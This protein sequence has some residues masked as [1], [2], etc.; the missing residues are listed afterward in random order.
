MVQNSQF[1]YDV[2]EGG[3]L[4]ERIVVS[5]AASTKTIM[6]I[7]TRE[8]RD[9]V[10]RPDGQLLEDTLDWYAQ[11]D[12][13]NVWYL[14]EQVTN[15]LYDDQGHFLNTTSGGSWEAGVNGAV[16]G[17]IMEA[18]PT[19][20]D[21]YYQEFNAND[22][23]DQAAVLAK[24]ESATVPK[25]TFNNLLRTRDTSVKEPTGVKDKRYAPGIGIIDEIGYD[26]ITGQVIELTKLT[27]VTLNGVEVNQL[28]SPTASQGT[29]VA[30][31]FVGGIRLNGAAIVDAGGDMAI[32]GAT[33]KTTSELVGT[34]EISLAE[35]QLN[36]S[37]RISADDTIGLRNVVATKRVVVKGAENV[38]I[39]NSRF[40]HELR[41]MMGAGDSTLDLKGSVISELN[42]DGGLGT[43][44]FN[45]QGG[46]SITKRKL[47]R[48]N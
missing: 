21:R 14:G 43:N 26:H 30:G 3:T 34:S 27:S 15:Y 12:N 23:L 6:G 36:G 46:N 24:G 7:Q 35:S 38:S 32:I 11:D 31:R 19:V 41:V 48:F 29:N 17:I 47:T 39:L 4:T 5:V 42:A 37:S 16:A 8:V 9:T 1:K 18:V 20:G 13:G 28:T 22:V 2:T 33:F 44:M 45:D 40:R 10:Y 25:G